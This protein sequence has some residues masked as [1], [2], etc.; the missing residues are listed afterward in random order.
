VISF[1]LNDGNFETESVII[2]SNHYVSVKIIPDLTMSDEEI[3]SVK[4]V[5]LVFICDFHFIIQSFFYF[6]N[7]FDVLEPE[8]VYILR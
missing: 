1:P 6:L 5:N 8:T 7:I 3:R 2:P 4:K